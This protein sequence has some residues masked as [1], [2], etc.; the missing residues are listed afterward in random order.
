MTV[1][2]IAIWDIIHSKQS[3]FCAQILTGNLALHIV[4]RQAFDA[5][6]GSVGAQGSDVSAPG[7][8]YDRPSK[9]PGVRARD[10][11]GHEPGSK[12]T[13]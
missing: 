10:R 6:F 3:A 1:R 4:S 9:V 12:T 2:C 8:P 5:L 7:L 13:E 11:K